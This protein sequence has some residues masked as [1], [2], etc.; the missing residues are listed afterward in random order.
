[1]T[2]IA[3]I[4]AFGMW[5]FG[6]SVMNMFQ[7]LALVLGLSIELLPQA[8]IAEA[9]GALDRRMGRETTTLHMD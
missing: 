6:H 1:M 4:G 3:P 8:G 9:Q 2:A 7:L 5:T